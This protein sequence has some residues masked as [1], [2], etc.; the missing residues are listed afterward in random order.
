MKKHS[1]IL[2]CLFQIWVLSAQV[3]NFS[4][5]EVANNISLLRDILPVD[6]DG[7]GDMDI[8]TGRASG[9][10][11]LK[12]MDGLG[13]FNATPVPVFSTPGIGLNSLEAA[14]LDGDGDLDVIIATGTTNSNS[15]IAWFENLDGVGQ[16]FSAM[17]T[18]TTNGDEFRCIATGDYDGDDDIDIA[19]GSYETDAVSW[20]QNTDGQGTFAAPVTFY[21]SANG[22]RFLEVADA[23]N[24]GDL[25]LFSSST[26]LNPSGQFSQFKNTDGLGTFVKQNVNNSDGNNAMGIALGDIDGDGDQ[27]FI[28]GIYNS[29]AIFRWLNDGSGGFTSK[30][31]VTTGFDGPI[32]VRL[33]DIENDGDLDLFVAA[34]TG[35]VIGFMQNNGNGV[36][37]NLT[38]INNS[39]SFSN[40]FFNNSR[41]IGVADLNDDGLT[42]IVA[43]SPGQL[44]VV[45]FKSVAPLAI[46][47]IESM[48]VSCF[49]L[50]DGT[51]T[52]NTNGGGTPPY[53][54]QLDNGISNSTGVFSGLA[55]GTYVIT[56]QDA[57]GFNVTDSVSIGQPSQ[58]ITALNVSICYGENYQFGDTT[59]STSGNYQNI[60]PAYSGCDSTVM[61][62]LTVLQQDE[63]IIPVTMCEGDTVVVEGI[64]YFSTGTY[65]I[66]LQNVNGCDS[67][68]TIEVDV[69]PRP[70]FSF[71]AESIAACKDELPFTLDAGNG[72]S[73]YLWNTGAITQSIEVSASGEYALTVTNANGCTNSDEITFQIKPSPFIHLGNDTLICD[74]SLPFT[75]D[76][77]AGFTSYLWQD[78][79]TGQT[80]SVTT[81]GTHNLSISVA[82]NDGCTN[83]DTI[84]IVATICTGSKEVALS[85]N[86]SI[87]PNPAS[88]EINIRF[89][90]F[91]VGEYT[92]SL[93]DIAS[94]LLLQKKISLASPHQQI[95]IDAGTLPTGIYWLKAGANKGILVKKVVVAQP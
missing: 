59:L 44:S 51:I 36:F 66:L 54:F 42:D 29:D 75:I 24:D 74:L 49:G 21:T 39:L 31:V 93:L 64:P 55:A 37:S 87:F 72:F 94:R 40:A 52:I 19:F 86:F 91:E 13:S 35:N 65:T 69:M 22:V 9:A 38:V 45:W 58:I 18:L 88:E 5:I 89:E 76:A 85:G 2:I 14:D 1:L 34:E 43:I 23:D 71:P 50:S 33:A 95:S 56:V 63:E 3:P 47:S 57:T 25:D 17:I 7:D 73:T 30:M 10:S 46:A 82:N 84:V 26:Y 78:G 15:Q 4:K 90:D 20:M 77:G 28:G 60:F 6:M 8:L 68:I 81:V 32:T 53:Y 27:D 41:L 67:I 92:L 12:N 61:L 70:G 80:F 11:W 16:T 83:S 62:Q 48:P 79:S